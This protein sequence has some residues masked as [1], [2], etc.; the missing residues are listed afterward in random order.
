[1]QN[2]KV[3]S[4]S[5][6][7]KIGIINIVTHFN[8]TYVTLTDIF[9]N[10]LFVRSGGLVGIKGPN[11]S[12]SVTSEEVTW[13]VCSF[14][15]KTAL[16]FL[17]FKISGVLYSRKMKAAFKIFKFQ[18]GYKI[19]RVFNNTAKAHNGIRLKKKRRL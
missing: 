19:L 11:R 15:K 13:A 10:V 9:G 4:M 12:T 7:N 6:S 2:K 1:M 8:N 16:K 3:S 5:I 14:L 17:I 18:R